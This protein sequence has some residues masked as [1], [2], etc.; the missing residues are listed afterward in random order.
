MIEWDCLLRAQK[1][2]PCCSGAEMQVYASGVYP[3]CLVLFADLVSFSCILFA[4]LNFTELHVLHLS[5]SLGLVW[6][7]WTP[8]M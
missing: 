2:R 6:C 1:K 8:Y 7:D 4:W 5:V 3:V